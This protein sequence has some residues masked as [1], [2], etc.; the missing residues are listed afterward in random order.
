[1]VLDERGKEAT[2]EGLA[3][4]L[5]KVKL[6]SAHALL[7][8]PLTAAR[9]PQ[10]AMAKLLRIRNLSI[11]VAMTST[12]TSPRCRTGPGITLTRA[13]SCWAASNS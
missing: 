1:M 2:S 12:A 11:T 9:G 5:A 4:L 7:H 10:E 3:E 13:E 8:T 6:H